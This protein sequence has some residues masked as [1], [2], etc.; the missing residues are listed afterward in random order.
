MLWSLS[1]KNFISS[2]LITQWDRSVGI[3]FPLKFAEDVVETAAQNTGISLGI[4]K[5]SKNEHPHHKQLLKAYFVYVCTLACMC[6]CMHVH[7]YMHMYRGRGDAEHSS[8]QTIHLISSFRTLDHDIPRIS[9]G[10]ANCNPRGKDTDFCSG[11]WTLKL[12]LESCSVPQND[13]WREKK[14]ITPKAE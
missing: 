7:A 1:T 10:W 11:F 5:V 9:V 14:I 4:F 12:T 2:Y 13:S 8:G 3:Y 6:A